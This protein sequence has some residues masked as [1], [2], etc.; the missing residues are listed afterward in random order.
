MWMDRGQAT[1]KGSGDGRKRR[2]EEGNRTWDIKGKGE[3]LNSCREGTVRRGWEAREVAAEWNMYTF[4]E[5][6]Q[7]LK[8]NRNF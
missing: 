5:H 4:T 7:C 1:R 2:G 3:F 8:Y 6:L